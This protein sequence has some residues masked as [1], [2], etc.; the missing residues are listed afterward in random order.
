MSKS[1]SPIWFLRE[2]IDPE[3]KEY[4]LLDY[5]KE[6]SKRLNEEN[7]YGIIKEISRIVKTL[8]EFKKYKEISGSIKKSL[9][10]EDVDY[11]N[12]FAFNDLLPEQRETLDLIIEESLEPLYGYS[13][14]CLDILKEEESKIKIFR[15]Q[16]KFDNVNSPANSG[17][18]IIRNMVTDKLLNYFFKSK[19]IMETT[20]GNREVSVLKKIHLKNSLFSLNYEYIYQEILNELDTDSKYSHKFYVVEIYENFEET[21]EIYRLAKEKFIEHIEI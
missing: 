3:H 6:I 20:D 10:K 18:V 11:V 5:L 9:E 21:S 8:N 17:I 1:I 19:V 7:C 13:E 12:S 15:I 16:S 14:I 4:V 2:P